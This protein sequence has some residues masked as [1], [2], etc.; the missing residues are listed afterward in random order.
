MQLETNG[1][2]FVENRSELIGAN[3]SNIIGLFAPNHFP[4]EISRKKEIIPS[5]SEMTTKAIEILSQDPNGFFLMVEGGRIDHGGHANNKTNVALETIEFHYAINTAISY[6]MV[7]DEVLLIITSDHETGG[8]K[9]LDDT[10]TDVTP[11]SNYT[12]E[13]NE[14][15]RIKRINNISVNWT[16]TYHT[17]QDVPFFGYNADFYGLE[18]HSVIDNTEIFDIMKTFISKSP[19]RDSDLIV[20]IIIGIVIPSLT[21]GGVL[22]LYF[23][24]KKKKTKI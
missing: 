9:I 7:H 18:N 20:I 22:I 6:S 8:L 4:Y 19:T 15:I 24:K 21:F 11:S 14:L 2:S 23:R 13:Q 3:S 17:S 10:L 5:L 1:Y 16:G 12:I